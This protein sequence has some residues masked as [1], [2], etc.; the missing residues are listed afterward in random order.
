MSVCVL[1]M[2]LLRILLGFLHLAWYCLWV[3][4]YIICS[5]LIYAPL[6]PKPTSN[7][8]VYIKNGCRNLPKAFHKM[9]L[10]FL[11]ESIYVMDHVY[12]LTWIKPSLC[13]WNKVNLII[14][15]YWELLHLWSSGRLVY[16][17]LFCVSFYL[18]LIL[19]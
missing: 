8:L 11:F 19:G 1:F 4:S 2:V 10:R 18:V 9:I 6:L 15:F 5:M 3:L 7:P 13:F 17:F 14:V 12:Y 16:N